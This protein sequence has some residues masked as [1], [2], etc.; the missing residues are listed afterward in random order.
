VESTGVTAGPLQTDLAI[1]ADDERPLS[2]AWQRWENEGGR[3]SDENPVRRVRTPERAIGRDEIAELDAEI[4]R[5]RRRL[6]RDFANGLVGNRYNTYQHRSRII[7][8]LSAKL[9]ALDL[10]Q[11]RKSEG[12]SRLAGI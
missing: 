8:Q 11:I 9:D 7:R 6:S 4:H 3:L 1:S 12:P 5:L 10:R 2:G